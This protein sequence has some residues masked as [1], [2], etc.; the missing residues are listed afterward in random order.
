MEYRDFSSSGEGL[1]NLVGL[2]RGARIT[3]TNEVSVRAGFFTRRDPATALLNQDFLTGGVAVA[4]GQTAISVSVL[5]GN[6]FRNSDFERAY[7][8][9]V[10]QFQQTILS[11]G[12]SYSL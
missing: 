6:L 10:T 9:S 4:I 8:G 11:A 1:R 5:D 2:Q 3:V 12:A 7:G